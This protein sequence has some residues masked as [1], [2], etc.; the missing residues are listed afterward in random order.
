MTGVSSDFD[1]WAELKVQGGFPTITPEQREQQR[2]RLQ[3]LGEEPTLE[4]LGAARGG[5]T[6]AGGPTATG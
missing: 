2:R 3:G 5:P 6:A 4:E 1:G